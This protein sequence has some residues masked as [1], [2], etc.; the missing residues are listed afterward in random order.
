MGF[1]KMGTD[2]KEK[3]FMTISVTLVV[4]LAVV[5]MIPIYAMVSTSLK[6]QEEVALQ[7]YLT[8][9]QKPQFS[10][11][12]KAFNS[13][14]V[15]LRNSVII[16]LSSTFLCLLIGTMA[17]YSLTGFNFRFATPLFFLIVVVTFLPYHIILIPITQLLKSLALLN[18]CLLYTS[19][20]ADDLLCVDLG[21]RRILKKK[22]YF[23]Y[24]I[25][26]CSLHSI[27]TIT[28]H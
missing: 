20:A 22:M 9:P 7:R 18:S 10:N 8:P 13:L 17:G 4:L 28:S 21:V 23:I 14:K 25:S 24:N 16:S 19:D 11:Y 1:K 12:L 26:L 15:G 6:T 27:T 5:W 3:H 2:M